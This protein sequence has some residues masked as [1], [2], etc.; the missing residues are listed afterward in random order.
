MATNGNTTAPLDHKNMA[1]FQAVTS[2]VSA[3]QFL[4]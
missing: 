4:V 1:R 3:S 2:A